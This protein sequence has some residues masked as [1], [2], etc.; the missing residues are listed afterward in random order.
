MIA[1]PLAALLSSTGPDTEVTRHRF[2]GARIERYGPMPPFDSGFLWMLREMRVTTAEGETRT[3]YVT[4]L[5]KNQDYPQPG[6][7]CDFTTVV[8]H[9]AG[10]PDGAMI[11]A[12]GGRDSP[13]GDVVEDLRCDKP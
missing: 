11:T 9:I 3:L 10:T 13:L 1:L 6:S 2:E 5:S 7:H 8:R 4:H 12:D